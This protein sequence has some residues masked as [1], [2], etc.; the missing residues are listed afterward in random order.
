MGKKSKGKAS[1]AKSKDKTKKSKA[2]HSVGDLRGSPIF[3]FSDI[4]SSDTTDDKKPN[5]LDGILQTFIK[6]H[7]RSFNRGR[8]EM[9]YYFPKDKVKNMLNFSAEEIQHVVE[10]TA[11]LLDHDNRREVIVEE[12]YGF[13]TARVPLLASQ[14]KRKIKYTTTYVVMLIALRSATDPAVK[15]NTLYQLNRVLLLDNFD[16]LMLTAWG[17]TKEEMTDLMSSRPDLKSIPKYGEF[18]SE[19]LNFLLPNI[20][21][22]DLETV[23]DTSIEIYRKTRPEQNTQIL[24]LKNHIN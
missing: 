11:D 9:L 19:N 20:D 3:T 15:A 24:D 23:L 21:R 22:S 13:R 14:K 12:E 18:L 7:S 17:L 1:K 16:S 2:V 10:V 8:K 6:T 5:S 4:Y